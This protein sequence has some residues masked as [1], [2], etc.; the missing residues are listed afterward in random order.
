M[1]VVAYYALH[2]GQEWL[3]WSL[4]SI[5]QFVDEIII[6]YAPAPSFG[7]GTNAVCPDTREDLM[8]IAKEYDVLWSDVKNSHWEGN[9][10]DA[11]VQMCIDEGADIIMPIDHDEIWDPITLRKTLDFVMSSSQQNY[12]V[13]MQHYWRSVGY[14]CYDEARPLRFIKPKAD[15]K[16]T[17][18]TPKEYGNVYHFGYAQSVALMRYKW[19][20]HGHLAELRPN[21]LEKIFIPWQPGMLDVHPTNERNFWDPVP[22]NRLHL[23]HLIGDHPY[24]DV[25]LI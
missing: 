21:W 25:D 19:L 11:A 3:E 10:R 13:P 6:V 24:Y 18:Y 7:H 17:A 14:V 8:D 5:R 16:D 9:H 20:I 22:F 12:I 15:N 4:Q 1:K 2:Y 23:E